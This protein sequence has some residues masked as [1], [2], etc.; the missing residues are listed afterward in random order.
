[1]K[2]YEVRYREARKK[3]ENKTYVYEEAYWA[4]IGEIEE[5]RLLP[6]LE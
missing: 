5:E 2:G 1:M 3:E 4:E 6:E